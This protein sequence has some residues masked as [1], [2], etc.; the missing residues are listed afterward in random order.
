MFQNGKMSLKKHLLVF[1]N[2]LFAVH[3]FAQPAADEPDTVIIPG[4]I[5]VKRAPMKAMAEVRVKY[6]YDV[7][8]KK[9]AKWRSNSARFKNEYRAWLVEPVKP[10]PIVDSATGAPQTIQAANLFAEMKVPTPV[11]L[12][13]HVNRFL[14]YTM[15]VS[16]EGLSELTEKN[17]AKFKPADG[18]PPVKEEI[19]AQ[20]VTSVFRNMKN[21]YPAQSV[22]PRNGRPEIIACTLDITVIVF[23]KP[24]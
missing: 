3:A 5:Y 16:K 9:K 18:S 19:I 6:G 10:Q 24:D 21:W 23:A 4:T 14:K 15:Y 13:A 22:N 20:Q 2:V 11:D 7:K 17:P 1:C 8:K 12:S